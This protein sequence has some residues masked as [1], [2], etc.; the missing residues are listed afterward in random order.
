MRTFVKVFLASGT[1]LVASGTIYWFVAYEPAGTFL[2]VGCGLATYVMAGY[3]WTRIRR[4]AEPVEDLG[5]SDP[6]AGAGEPITSFTMD[7]PWPLVLGVGVAVLAGG[8]VFGPALLILGAILVVI[9][10]IGLMRESIA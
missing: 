7:S 4:S 1:F 3:A 10:A 8:L 5:D 2:L 6:G 9:A